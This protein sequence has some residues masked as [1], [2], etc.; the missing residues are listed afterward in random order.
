M[1]EIVL[2]GDEPV[3]LAQMIAGL[4]EGNIAADPEKARLLESTRGAVEIRVPDAGV[5]IGLKFVPGSLT[6]TS[7]PVAGANLRITTD[8]DALLGLSTVP[9][10]FGLPD[11]LTEEGRATVGQLLTRKL[12]LR[13]LPLGI[14]MLRTV[15]RLLN[16]S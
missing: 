13:G 15:N 6:V 10:R 8:S 4:V 12:K 16:V 9:L 2:E 3:G 1:A 5:T 14:G 11:P 7:G